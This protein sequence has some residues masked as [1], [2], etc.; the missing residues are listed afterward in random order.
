MT[1]INSIRDDV[2]IHNSKI[3][4]AKSASV[5]APKPSEKAG[6]NFEVERKS[7]L[8]R[9]NRQQRGKDRRQNNRRNHK[10]DVLLDTRSHHDRRHGIDRRHTKDEHGKNRKKYSN[11]RRHIDEYS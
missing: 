11:K 10:E 5:Q 6:T 3:K 1:S 7:K 2:G 8:K 9:S 4:E